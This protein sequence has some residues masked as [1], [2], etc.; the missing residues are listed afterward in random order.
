MMGFLGDF[1][2][3]TSTVLLNAAGTWVAFGFFIEQAKTLNQ[4]RLFMSAK[5]GSPATTDLTC[6]LYS[7][8]T[9]IPGASIDGPRPADTV[10]AAGTWMQWSGFTTPLTPCTQ[11]WLVIKNVNSVP[12][13]ND[14]TFSFGGYL[15]TAGVGN[16]GC[17]FAGG[18]R[19]G[20]EYGWTKVGTVNS[21]TAW[22]TAGL[23]GVTGP[24]L[25]FS[26]GTYDGFPVQAAT[27][28]NTGTVANRAFG[29]SE[30]GLR[31]NVPTGATFNVIGIGMILYRFGT[32]G[33]ARYRI[34]KGVTLAATSIGVNSNSIMA[35]GNSGDVVTDFFSAPVAISSADNPIRVTFGDATA[36]DT[37]ANGYN[38]HLITVDG[39]SNSLPLMPMNGTLQK[40]IT[41]DNTATP[42]V[43]T[44]TAT[45]LFPFALL[46]DTNGEFGAGS[47]TAQPRNRG[48]SSGGKL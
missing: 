44:D 22:A 38:S 29:K 47:G 8:A 5:A 34:Y 43:F 18:S 9:G 11:Y 17:Q 13:T 3:T 32:P 4:V 1:S 16:G 20:I 45:D 27:R 19:L 35:T 14:A 28:P 10:G 33:N 15:Q 26:D 31:F 36:A 42:V 7:D 48:I 40:T 30:V 6:D 2:S 21:G 39:D 46:L 41:S 12:G 25:G 23:Q 24:R 37:N